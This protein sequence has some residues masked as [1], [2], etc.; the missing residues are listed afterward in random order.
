MSEL[1]IK[2]TQIEKSDQ[3]AIRSLFEG[4]FERFWDRHELFDPQNMDAWLDSLAEDN[5][6]RMF[7]IRA[8]RTRTAA[9]GKLY[10][11]GLSGL[12]QIDLISRHGRLVFIMV[13]KGG[14]ESTIQNHPATKSAFKSMLD[15]GF[16]ELG[17]NKIWTEVYEHND[18]R[19]VLE[20]FGF[21]PEGVRVDSFWYD[22]KYYNSII[23]SLTTI[24]YNKRE[25]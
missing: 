16:K 9:P 19:N 10:V 20:Q 3:A 7:A 14:H 5:S 12:D 11:V 6:K 18:V 8:A 17:L 21:I 15:Y 24:E 13:D 2:L 25:E 4:G 23:C 1:S 22:G